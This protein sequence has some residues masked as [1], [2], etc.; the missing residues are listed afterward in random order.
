MFDNHYVELRP[1][2]VC[3]GV[4]VF[5]IKEIPPNK[6]IFEYVPKDLFY[7]WSILKDNSVKKLVS[8]LCHVN[9][10]GFWIAGHPSTLGMSYYV[11]H[12]NKPNVVFNYLLGDYVSITNIKINEELLCNY[13]EEEKDWLI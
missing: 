8:K 2:N 6:R 10:E 7:P 5:A 13:P 12:S 4:G 3:K 1:S 11:N 9:E